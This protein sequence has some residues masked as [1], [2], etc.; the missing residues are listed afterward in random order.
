[1]MSASRRLVGCCVYLRVVVRRS[2][3]GCRMHAHVPVHG[4]LVH[5]TSTSKTAGTSPATSACATG[6]SADATEGA[7]RPHHSLAPSEDES[8][9]Y[10]ASGSRV[11]LATPTTDE[12]QGALPAATSTGCRVRRPGRP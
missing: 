1:M 7:A 6:T 9:M 11:E 4:V 12:S 8:A 2:L 3:A 5:S 10:A